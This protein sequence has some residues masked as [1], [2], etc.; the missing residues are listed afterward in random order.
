MCIRD[1]RELIIGDRQ[2]GKTSIATDA[3]LNQKDKDC[4]LYTSLGMLLLGLVLCF[5]LS[6]RG[7]KRLETVANGLDALAQGQTQQQHSQR[8]CREHPHHAQ[9]KVR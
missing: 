3:I 1:R 9:G 6:W 4:L 7:A 2:T 5:W 8:C